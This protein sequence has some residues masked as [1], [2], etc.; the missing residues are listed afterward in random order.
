MRR[1]R[2]VSRAGPTVAGRRR[3]AAGGAL[4]VSRTRDTGRLAR[5]SRVPTGSTPVPGVARARPPAGGDRGPFPPVVAAAG[6]DRGASTRRRCERDGLRVTH[7]RTSRAHVLSRRALAGSSGESLPCRPPVGGSEPLRQG[8]RR[9]GHP[10]PTRHGRGR[11]RL[12]GVT[13][14]ACRCRRPERRK[15]PLG[16]LGPDPER[17]PAHPREPRPGGEPHAEA[18][19][20]RNVAGIADVDGDQLPPR[21]FQLRHPAAECR[22]SGAS[23]VGRPQQGGRVDQEPAHAVGQRVVRRGGIDRGGRR[24]PPGEAE[25]RQRRPRLRQPEDEPVVAAEFRD[26]RDIDAGLRREPAFEQS[27]PALALQGSRGNGNEQGDGGVPPGEAGALRQHEI[28]PGRE[29]RVVGIRWQRRGQPAAIAWA[30]LRQ[31]QHGSRAR[32]RVLPVLP[33]HRARDPG[34]GRTAAAGPLHPTTEHR[35]RLLPRR[36]DEPAEP[37]VG[38]GREREDREGVLRASVAG[39]A[40]ARRP[41]G[42]AARRHRRVHRPV[43]Q[44]LGAGVAGGEH[45]GREGGQHRADDEPGDGQARIRPLGGHRRH[46][47]ARHHPAGQRQY[48]Q[49]GHRPPSAPDGRDD[50]PSSL[51]DR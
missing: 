13:R 3:G 35:R 1:A 17:R 41:Q 34:D 31:A 22:G 9:G 27:D 5:P 49:N 29:R 30:E 14:T 33:R 20:S 39:G 2:P 38:H 21:P 12:R 37:S 16:D 4:Q 42:I 46:Q 15:P 18:G 40:L 25:A 8:G 24:Q 7:R 45:H 6:D 51:T 43:E 47:R 36:R 50:R 19:Q 28:E 32:P 44:Q 48:E 11:G 26:E 10:F 23:R